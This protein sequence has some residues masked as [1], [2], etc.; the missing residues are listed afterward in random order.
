MKRWKQVRWTEAGQVTA[1]LGWPLSEHD[2]QPPELFFD[3]LLAEG[4]DDDAA[5]FLGQALPRYEAVAWATQ[6]VRDLAPPDLPQRDVEA[7]DAALRWLTDPS[8]NRRRAA[9]DAAANASGTSPQRMCALAVFFSGGSLAPADLEPLLA[10]KDAAGKFA[11]G[12]VLTAATDS[13]RRQEG[14]RAALA[15]GEAL[16]VG[17]EDG[18]P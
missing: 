4:R 12:A 11:A 10:P 13:G 17:N 6:A 16:A 1:I 14:L 8:D 9:F 2:A 18:R 7:L 15:L 5:M 3:R